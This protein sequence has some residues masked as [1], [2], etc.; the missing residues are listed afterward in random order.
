MKLDQVEMFNK[1]CNYYKGSSPTYIFPSMPQLA[2][3]GCD[4]CPATPVT[5]PLWPGSLYKSLEEE[6]VTFSLEIFQT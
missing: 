3:I 1:V 6:S 2:I 5:L 4:A